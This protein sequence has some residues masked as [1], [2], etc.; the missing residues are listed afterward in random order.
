LL[1]ALFAGMTAVLA[2]AVVKGVDFNLATEIAQGLSR[3]HLS[4]LRQP[5]R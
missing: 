2:K 5:V 3:L 4:G 1:S